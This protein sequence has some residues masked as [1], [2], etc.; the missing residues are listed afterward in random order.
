M[1][2]LR[3]LLPTTS[4]S[5][6]MA[7]F[8]A[9]GSSGGASAVVEKVHGEPEYAQ[10]AFSAAQIHAATKPG[11]TYVWRVVSPGAPETL[12]V[13]TFG[14]VDDEGADLTRETRE[15]GGEVIDGPKSARATWEELEGHGRFPLDALTVTATTVSVPA[16]TWPARLYEVRRAD[17]DILRLWFADELPG[18]PVRIETMKD[19]L[20]VETRELIEHR[21]GL[22]LGRVTDAAYE[23]AKAEGRIDDN[24]VVFTPAEIADGTYRAVFGHGFDERASDLLMGTTLTVD[25]ARG[26]A[27]ITTP[28]QGT[29]VLKLTQR[30]RSEWIPNCMSSTGYILNEAANLEPATVTV[31]GATF[32]SAS[33]Q[34]VCKAERVVLIGKPG[35]PDLT[36]DLPRTSP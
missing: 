4:L 34:G 17:D 33:L 6:L 28:G 15:P 3:L 30:P 13:M 32:E 11:R 12:S 7:L 29:T 20:V 22:V 35:G 25:R 16:G 19:G 36:F 2:T 18:A 1:P 8:A 27:T 26:T 14:A 5:L 24:G 21:N 10:A 9:C 31:V 23:L